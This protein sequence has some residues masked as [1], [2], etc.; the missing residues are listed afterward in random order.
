MYGRKQSV[1]SIG[2]GGVFAEQSV[3]SRP[4]RSHEKRGAGQRRGVGMGAPTPGY[5][6]MSRSRVFPGCGAALR[7]EYAGPTRSVAAAATKLSAMTLI[8][9]VVAVAAGAQEPAWRFAEPSFVVELPRDHAAHPD[10]RIEWWYYTGHVD[11]AGG[12]RFGYQLTFFRYGV[13]KSPSN[14]SRWAVRD[15]YLAHVA[16]SDLTGRRH[17]HADR[18]NRA[19]AG[20]A[21]AAVDRYEVWNEDWRV[22]RTEDGR[23]R[24]SART[25]HFGLELELDEGK[26]AVLNGV[27]GYSRKGAS[28]GNASHYYS[29]TRMPTRGSIVFDGVAYEVEGASWMDHEFG[30]SFLEEDQAGWDWL[31][32][33][34]DEE[35]E[36]MVYQLRRRDGS[37]DPYSSGTFVGRDGRATRLEAGDY[38]LTPGRTWRSPG[39]GATYPV[40]WRVE[41]PS[42]QLTL[43]VRAAFD[44]QEMRTE[45]TT[46][47]TYWEGAIEVTGTRAG[48]PVAGRGYLE[49]TGY[50][51]RPMSE[52]FR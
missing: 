20:W 44:A 21:G 2:R 13:E 33:Q 35:V 25:A 7:R 32:I 10:Y 17:L 11:A 34:L 28:D 24:L 50:T 26:G 39:S 36:L 9:L 31:S 46:T 41:V 49:M 3:R 29:F 45:D 15:L 12:R 47:V 51:G 18:L 6:T 16:V 30:S 48:R 4:S 22:V 43:D 38:T 5:R 42:L 27:A 1:T 40:E 37:R 14:P 8:L 52:V 19:G 23:H